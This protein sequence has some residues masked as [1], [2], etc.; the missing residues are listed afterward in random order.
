MFKREVFSDPSCRS[1]RSRELSPCLCVRRQKVIKDEVA[2]LGAICAGTN[3]PTIRTEAKSR[4]SNGRNGLGRKVKGRDSAGRNPPGRN[5]AETKTILGKMTPGQNGRGRQ[6]RI[7]NF[8]R[9]NRCEVRNT[10]G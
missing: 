9:A 2:R 6:V 10:L 1:V 4:R 3:Y 5:G 7:A 8:P